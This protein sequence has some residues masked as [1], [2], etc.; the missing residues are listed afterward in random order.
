MGLT[1]SSFSM[2]LPGALSL[3]QVRCGGNSHVSC[4]GGSELALPAI[5]PGSLSGERNATV[6][7]QPRPKDG[8]RGGR[9]HSPLTQQFSP[10]GRILQMHYLADKSAFTAWLITMKI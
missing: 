4:W 7:R 9:Q 6:H 2:R 8:T 1:P 10:W 5:N 3:L